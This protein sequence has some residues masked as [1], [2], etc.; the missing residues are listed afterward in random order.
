MQQRLVWAKKP[1]S[2][3]VP[4][5]LTVGI[6]EVKDKEYAIAYPNVLLTT[7]IK[8]LLYYFNMNTFIRC[9]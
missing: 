6:L 7:E 8:I 5:Q 9:S 2:T 4:F 3:P 1:I